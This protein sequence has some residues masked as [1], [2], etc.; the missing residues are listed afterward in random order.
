APHTSPFVEPTSV[1]AQLSPAARSASSTSAGIDDTGA[2]TTTTS[3][4]ATASAALGRDASTAPRATAIAS[5]S[6]SASYPST[7][8][9]PA[10]FAARP[11]DAPINPVP[12]S[13]T[14]LVLCAVTLRSLTFTAGLLYP[15]WLE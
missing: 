7:D 15:E 8:S 6:G 2:A 4:P 14:R 1:T 3:A 9:I 11:T 13:A 5:A 10:R 12:M